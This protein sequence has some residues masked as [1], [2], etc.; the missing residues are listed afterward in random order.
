[1]ESI[2]LEKSESE[3]FFNVFVDCLACQNRSLR[4]NSVLYVG[5]KKSEEKWNERVIIAM[6]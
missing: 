1:V 3:Y 4:E 2:L 5:I 6:A